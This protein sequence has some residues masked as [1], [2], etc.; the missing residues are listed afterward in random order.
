MFIACAPSCVVE[1]SLV[2]IEAVD[3]DIDPPA[4][5]EDIGPP[6]GRDKR[7]T[8]AVD[9]DIGPPAGRDKRDPPVG[10]DKRDPP[11]VDEDIDPPGTETILAVTIAAA[12]AKSAIP[13]TARATMCFFTDAPRRCASAAFA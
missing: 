4:A 2:E 1:V 9:G 7:D 8:P 3:G 13:A 12:E 10:R 6:A 5:D 11:A